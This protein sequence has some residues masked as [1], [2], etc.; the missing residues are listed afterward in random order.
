[1]RPGQPGLGR[2][3]ASELK[4]GK[5]FPSVK[6]VDADGKRFSTEQLNGHYT[7]LVAGCL[8]CPAFLGSYGDVEA[9]Y[10]DYS[11]K[12]V[13]FYYVYRALA[14]P[15]NNG[16]V[17]P[18]SLEERLMHVAEA[19]TRLKTRVPWLADNMNNEFKRTIGNTN[20]S[21]F[22]LDPEGRIVHMQ[23]WSNGD[24]LRAALQEHVGQ[25]EKP[26]TVDDLGLPSFRMLPNTRGTVLPRTKVPGIMV[27]LRIEPKQTGQPFYVKLRAEAEQSVLENGSGKVYLG[28]HIDPIHNTHWNN[29]VDP[30]HFEVKAP[31]GT[32]VAP[33]SGD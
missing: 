24:R 33:A 15:E 9:A 13:K 8:T 7:V 23:M 16:I 26:T 25:V 31:S 5:P 19:R 22:V 14:H 20:N 28:F 3:A 12:G 10:R 21:E 18:F 29:H 2:L 11:P 32:K 30:L 6:I 4:V 27:P 1:M 17:K